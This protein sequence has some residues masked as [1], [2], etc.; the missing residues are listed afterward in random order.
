MRDLEVLDVAQIY[1]TEYW[2]RTKGGY[3]HAVDVVAFLIFQ[4]WNWEINVYD[5]IS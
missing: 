4:M 2:D 1:K 5:D 3:S